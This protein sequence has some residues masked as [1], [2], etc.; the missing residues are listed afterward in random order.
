MYEYHRMQYGRYVLTDVRFALIPPDT[1]L[2]S[3]I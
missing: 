2:W 3:Q 1:T